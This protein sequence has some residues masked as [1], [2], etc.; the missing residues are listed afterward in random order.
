MAIDYC[1]DLPG[2]YLGDH[3]P[4]SVNDELNMVAFDIDAT[5]AAL[6]PTLELDNIDNNIDTSSSALSSSSLSSSLVL[7][8][9]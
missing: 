4:V 3:V 6:L 2:W 9:V 8:A 5:L 1:S 7:S